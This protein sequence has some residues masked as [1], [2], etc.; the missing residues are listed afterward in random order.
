MMDFAYDGPIFL[1]PLNPSYPSWPVLVTT[2]PNGCP[3][4]NC[5]YMAR[6]G[7]G[8]GWETRKQ[9]RNV[10]KGTSESNLNSF[11]QTP[12]PFSFILHMS[13]CT[14]LS[15]ALNLKATS[16]VLYLFYCHCGCIRADRVWSY[17]VFY[18][19]LW[20][21]AKHFMGNWFIRTDLKEHSLFYL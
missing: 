12:S 16:S 15:A 17:A 9:F 7:T 6:Q 8:W 2:V 19:Y 3:C 11:I 4:F 20:I 21:W 5:E 18:W 14:W 13:T 1:V 10:E